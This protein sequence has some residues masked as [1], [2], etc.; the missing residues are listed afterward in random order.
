MKT[1]KLLLFIL[2]ASISLLTQAQEETTIPDNETIAISPLQEVQL[3]ANGIR[4]PL[5][6]FPAKKR[7][8]LLEKQRRVPAAFSFIT[9]QDF[10]FDFI[11]KGKNEDRNYTQGTAFVYSHPNLI[12]FP[13]FY[14]HLWLFHKMKKNSTRYGSSISLG[15][16]AFTPRELD[17]IK[18]IVGDR[19]FSFLLYLSATTTFKF[20]KF[21]VPRYHSFT[22]N[23]GIFG[24]NVGY[25]FQSY[26]HK[27]LIT[28]RSK[29]P[30]GWNTQISKGGAPALL[31]DYNRFRPLLQYSKSEESELAWFDLGWNV[32]GSIGYYNRANAGIFSRIGWLRKENQA[33]WNGVWSVLGSASQE[34]DVDEESEEDRKKPVKFC[35]FFLYTKFTTTAMIRNAMLQGQW[36]KKSEYTM[37]SSWTKKLL[38]ECELGLVLSFE[39]QEFV[40]EAPRTKSIFIRAVYRT[41]EFDSGIF[42]KRSHYFGSAGIT[43][44]IITTKRIHYAS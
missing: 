13:L 29:D 9:D 10:F 39:R 35:E 41:P 2:F 1:R 30:K 8:F 38:L 34:L 18:P 19:P 3:G 28:G 5:S 20:R 37:P 15:G 44:P 42:P 26:A 33:R 22:V 12:N 31:I 25:A 23:Y 4:I 14:P 7:T 40:D 21:S 32:G 27:Q 36:I 16:T 6:N 43:F 24:T 17:S 11:Q